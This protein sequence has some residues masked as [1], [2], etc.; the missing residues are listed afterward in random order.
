MTHTST[1][2][3]LEKRQQALAT[4]ENSILKGFLIIFTMLVFLS[5]LSAIHDNAI[6]DQRCNEAVAIYLNNKTPHNLANS[7]LLCETK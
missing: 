6:K 7:N 1:K 4:H 5:V 2:T 3:W